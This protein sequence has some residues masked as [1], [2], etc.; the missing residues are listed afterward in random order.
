MRGQLVRVLEVVAE[1]LFVLEAHEF[2]SMEHRALCMKEY[3][4][5]STNAQLDP[6][7]MGPP[8]SVCSV[9]VGFPSVQRHDYALAKSQD[10]DSID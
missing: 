7:K 6:M 4:C 5:T 8:L 10:A 1:L 9:P 3:T 2:A